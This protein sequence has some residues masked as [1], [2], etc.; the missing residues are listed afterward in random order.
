M[1][2]LPRMIAL[3]SAMLAFAVTSALA[4]T[5]TVKV[6]FA[7]VASGRQCP[8]G[9]YTVA[10]DTEFN[11]VRLQS[12]DGARHFQWII[13]PGQ[14]SPYDTSVVLTFDK[15]GN[16]YSLRTVQYRDKT[17]RRLDQKVPEYVP[18]RT[19]MGQ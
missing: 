12:A 3:A 7:F 19:I 11:V 9:V 10:R 8:A 4:E 14:P 6:P 1:K 16:D 15:W 18:T 2:N 5:T 17:T 13:G